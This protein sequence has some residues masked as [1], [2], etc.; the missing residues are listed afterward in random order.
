MK[1]IRSLLAT[2]IKSNVYTLREYC[3]KFINFNKTF[4]V[5][6]WI[7]LKNQLEPLDEDLYK[8]INSSIIIVDPLIPNILKDGFDK[9]SQSFTYNI[10]ETEGIIKHPFIRVYSK[11]EN[12]N[13]NF[14]TVPLSILTVLKWA[15]LLVLYYFK[16]PVIHYLKNSKKIPV[17]FSKDSN[18]LYYVDWNY[19]LDSI[20]SYNKLKYISEENF[21]LI[22]C[23]FFPNLKKS[24]IID[25]YQKFS[26]ASPLNELSYIPLIDQISDK[27]TWQKLLD[28]I[29]PISMIYILVCCILYRKVSIDKRSKSHNSKAFSQYIQCSGRL[30]TNDYIDEL[31]LLNKIEINANVLSEEQEIKEISIN[32]KLRIRKSIEN[33]NNG[34]FNSNISIFG[35]E[36]PIQS[37]MMYNNQYPRK[38]GLPCQSLLRLL[39]PNE[40]GARILLK[41]VLYSDYLL[42]EYDHNNT[43]NIL[44]EYM[45]KKNIRVRC[46]IASN[47]L[48]SFQKLLENSRNISTLQSL[49]QICPISSNINKLKLSNIAKLPVSEYETSNTNVIKFLRYILKM[50]IPRKLFGTRN[51][52][53][54]F[55]NKKL[56]V[57]VNLHSRET[58][59]VHQ[60]MSKI[61]ISNWI[62]KIYTK[63]EE[64]IKKNIQDN[65][66][67]TNQYKKKYKS[68][69]TIAK[70]YLARIIYF[71]ITSI[72]VPIIRRHFY[73]TDIEGSSKLCYFRYPTW[74]KIV[75]IADLHFKKSSMIES[76]D[77]CD[78]PKIDASCIDNIP[79]LRWIPKIRGLRP[80]LNLSRAGSGVYLLKNLNETNLE[81]NKKQNNNG[82]FSFSPW[83]GGD[84]PVSWMN[85]TN[86]WRSQNY[87]ENFQI[88][89]NK[90]NQYTYSN[91]NNNKWRP[92]SNNT[93]DLLRPSAN[94]VLFYI[95]RIIR[96]Y[97]LY[98]INSNYSFHSPTFNLLGCSIIRYSDIHKCIK[99][100]WKYN[101]N[102]GLINNHNITTS[103]NLYKL[104]HSNLLPK[105]YMVKAD[106][107]NC[108]ENINQNKIIEILEGISLPTEIPLITIYNRIL[109]QTYTLPPF[110]NISTGII[111][112]NEN[113]KPYFLTS[114][115]KLKT[116]PVM[117]YEE[118]NSKYNQKL[119]ENNVKN[120]KYNNRCSNL[121]N[122]NS[123]HHVISQNIFIPTISILGCGKCGFLT[124]L[125]STRTIKWSDAIK[126]LKIHLSCNLMKLR[127]STRKWRIKNRKKTSIRHV[128]QQNRGI[129]QGSVLSHLLCSLYY[130][131]LDNQTD[132]LKLL[133]IGYNSELNSTSKIKKLS[134]SNNKRMSDDNYLE[135]NNQYS[136]QVEYNYNNKNNKIKRIKKSGIS[137]DTNFQTNKRNIES[138]YNKE[139]IPNET[140]L[141]INFDELQSANT[142]K[143][144]KF[145][146]NNDQEKNNEKFV[147]D[148]KYKDFVIN[149][150]DYIH[151]TKSS[152]NLLLRW[153]DDFLFLSTNKSSA[154]EFLDILCNKHTWG[155]NLTEDKITTN[156]KWKENTESEICDSVAWAGMKFSSDPNGLECMPLPWKSVHNISI[157]D[158]I[159]L[160]IINSNSKNK[161]KKILINPLSQKGKY[162][163]SVIGVRIMA[164]LDMRIR[165]GLN[166][167]IELN[168]KDTVYKNIVT[169]MYVTALKLLATI[170]RIKKV[171]FGFI[172][173]KF[174]LKIFEWI[175]Q[176]CISN[177]M[178]HLKKNSSNL[179]LKLSVKCAIYDAI[180]TAIKPRCNSLGLDVTFNSFG[181][182]LAIASKL[183]KDEFSYIPPQASSIIT[184]QY[185][186]IPK[187]YRSNKKRLRE[188]I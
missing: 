28:R 139:N 171:H 65:K 11:S 124:D 133:N 47:L 92:S 15:T 83:I 78:Y 33:K 185:S 50:I 85:S 73:V 24:L 6:H 71:I 100:W 61:K 19:I 159:S 177:I 172:N 183:L 136:F 94:N 91:T 37:N 168:T 99:H 27:I 17:S 34:I 63:Y 157:M 96:T 88:K 3:E 150:E 20:S 176:G 169:T 32:R 108:Y 138:I 162:M 45:A 23:Y 97:L 102:K 174:V 156:F 152:S 116:V 4:E 86:R 154:L 106:L 186:D 180:W 181:K 184:S 140:N 144:N 113:S 167:D 89:S 36:I 117:E 105:V 115:G 79:R 72:I 55:L 43:M 111:G 80:I 166:F 75:R 103:L 178:L 12:V 56:P 64:K 29:G 44:N 175:S 173:P 107:N 76:E 21:E 114:K 143:Q 112:I 84:T 158:T 18:N 170:K 125:S 40:I 148:K 41:F 1:D 164:Y 130:G 141:A 9:I 87:K 93:V 77:N 110:E 68:M 5:N 160:I 145:T 98:E 62:R 119:S 123:L 2:L 48:E 30:L 188:V 161:W 95:A 74:I 53:K 135:E 109:S 58:L 26:L 60:I 57:I 147:K 163:W 132:V 128:V 134:I 59:K 35:I 82:N 81:N 104:N 120:Y 149:N 49:A 31:R 151:Q 187:L 13:I 127:T 46:F 101:V 66:K 42:S 67:G 182:K 126:L 51:N 121:L 122:K 70:R 52:F 54:Y 39:P 90:S 118:Y 153:V 69:I 129:P 131:R 14:K 179:E 146:L 38:G 8:L 7:N 25:N 22:L 155:S 16:N 165:N 10:E 142:L 137:L